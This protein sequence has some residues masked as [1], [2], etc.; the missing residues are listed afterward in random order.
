ML[1]RSILNVVALRLLVE[2]VSP[3]LCGLQFSPRDPLPLEPVA[4]P[5]IGSFAP[6]IQGRKFYRC[7]ALLETSAPLP[8]EKLATPCVL[9]KIT[10]KLGDVKCQSAS[11]ICSV[12]SRDAAAMGSMTF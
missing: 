1:K 4:G 8:L 2:V 5:C 6:L 10:D 9:S 7:P 3:T 11:A 12:R